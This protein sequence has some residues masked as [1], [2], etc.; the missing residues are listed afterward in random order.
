[1]TAQKA[2][3]SSESGR[4]PDPTSKA[5]GR[6]DARGY[7]YLLQNEAF[8]DGWV[9][10]GKSRRSGRQRAD[11]LNAA[12]GTGIP[13]LHKFIFEVETLDCDRAERA[14]FERL[15]LERQ[16]AQEFFIVDIALA[17]QVIREECSKV[18]C[19]IAREV[20]EA[21]ALRAQEL[22][23]QRDAALR[24]EQLARVPKSA[25]TTDPQRTHQATPGRDDTQRR[26]PS[27]PTPPPS[28]M[29][30]AGQWVTPDQVATAW[31]SRNAAII[32]QARRDADHRSTPSEPRVPLAEESQPEFKWLV[33]LI[34]L[35][36][37]IALT[38]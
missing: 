31:A 34:V 12:A 38:I 14:V 36:L 27:R 18:T 7:V 20:D 23:Q 13:K 28:A 16:G 22:R 8:K 21:N 6:T 11:E 24:R 10:I 30:P 1:M 32:E 9:K 15:R 35:T 37:A 19:E 4:P 25:P 3:N 33:V 17:E 26:R 29:K 2:A 5:R